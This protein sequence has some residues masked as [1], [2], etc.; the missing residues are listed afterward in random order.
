LGTSTEWQRLAERDSDPKSVQL[1]AG[2][3]RPIAAD[4][5]ERSTGQI[6][7]LNNLMAA[8]GACVLCCMPHRPSGELRGLITEAGIT[9]PEVWSMTFGKMWPN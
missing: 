7:R 9:Y 1:A 2:S 5:I 4:H 8:V 6:E 3:P